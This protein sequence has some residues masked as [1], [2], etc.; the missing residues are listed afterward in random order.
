MFYGID[1]HTDSFKAAILSENSDE[2]TS[3]VHRP[4]GDLV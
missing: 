1:L 2:L 4:E 3:S